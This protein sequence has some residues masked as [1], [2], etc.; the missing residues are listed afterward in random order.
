ML[1][2]VFYKFDVLYFLF[3]STLTF[4]TFIQN[5]H[6]TNHNFPVK[7]V[8]CTTPMLLKCMDSLFN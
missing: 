2:L 4:Y 7:S 1:N 8:T 3:Y 6:I 5:K